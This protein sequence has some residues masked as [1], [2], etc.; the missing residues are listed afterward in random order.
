M[1]SLNKP[2]YQEMLKK[3]RLMPFIV[4]DRLAAFI[5]FYIGYEYEENKYVRDNPW[6]LLNDDEEG[7]TCWIDQLITDNNSV[8]PRLSYRAWREFKAFIKRT[9]P[10]VKIIKWK[11]WKKDWG[12]SKTRRKNV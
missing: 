2:Y 1:I 5:T 12:E 4:D 3:A 9:Y 7:N 8:N 10:K 6:E 11:R